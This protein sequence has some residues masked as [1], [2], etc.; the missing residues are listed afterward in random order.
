MLTQAISSTTPNCSQQQKQ[1]LA[2]VA[3][4]LLLQRDKPRPPVRAHRIVRRILLLQ[5]GGKGIELRLRL[6]QSR[7]RVQT[8]NGAGNEPHGAHRRGC[9][10]P[11]ESGG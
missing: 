9:G 1:H 3:D 5:M 11:G 10:R 8:R 6:G 7:S 2:G 4:N